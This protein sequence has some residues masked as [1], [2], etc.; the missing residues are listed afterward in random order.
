MPHELTQ[1]EEL[2]LESFPQVA[3][4]F[5]QFV[6]QAALD[7]REPFIQQLFVRLAR[8]C[9][10]ANRLPSVDPGTA[11]IEIDQ[12]EIRAHADEC[13]NLSE[14]LR[15]VFGNLDSYW[16]VFDPTRRE[17]PVNGSLARDIAEI[18]MDLKGAL[19]LL[20]SGTDLNDVY[21]QWRFD[22][23]SH[24]ARHAGSSLKVL[25]LNSELP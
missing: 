23:R 21:W 15:K 14:K 6:E 9:E 22:F 18:C 25:L 19:N 20:G 10:V 12:K 3:Q 5:C 24:W 7:L 1:D 11:D 16:D 2:A 4:E 13:F 17:E 8:L